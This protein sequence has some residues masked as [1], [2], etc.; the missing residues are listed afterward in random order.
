MQTVKFFLVCSALLPIAYANT[1]SLQGGASQYSPDPC[2]WTTLSTIIAF[3]VGHN[4]SILN[5]TSAF[6]GHPIPLISSRLSPSAPASHNLSAS[7]CCFVVQDTIDVRYWDGGCPRKKL[8][9]MVAYQ[10]NRRLCHRYR[11]ALDSNNSH[12]VRHS[13]HRHHSH[14]Q[15]FHYHQDTQSY[16]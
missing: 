3:P 11:N 12:H 5:S 16:L 15:R 7:S 1:L 13:V 6:S 8:R 10:L 4:K 2:F 14:D 9:T